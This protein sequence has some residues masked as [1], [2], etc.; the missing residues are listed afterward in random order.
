MGKQFKDIKFGDIV[1]VT[2][3]FHVSSGHDNSNYDDELLNKIY[4]RYRMLET[5]KNSGVFVYYV[6]RTIEDRGLVYRRLLISTEKAVSEDAPLLVNQHERITT[7]DIRNTDLNDDVAINR[8]YNGAVMIF[9]TSF[10]SLVKIHGEII[11]AILKGESIKMNQKMSSLMEL[12]NK[13]LC[14]VG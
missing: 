7:I 1:Y 12:K 11:D 4:G 8:L 10:E 6:R 5:Y 3:I 9:S 2:T 13:E 14:L